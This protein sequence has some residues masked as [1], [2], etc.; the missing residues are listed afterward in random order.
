[1]NSF[2]KKILSIGLSFFVL[3]STSSFSVE[4]HYCC[5][6]LIDVGVFVHAETCNSKS[7]N[8]GLI[9]CEDSDESCCHNNHFNKIGQEDLK[10]SLDNNFNLIPNVFIG[11]NNSYYDLFLELR[12]NSTT[13]NDYRPPLLLRNF[14]I[15]YGTFLI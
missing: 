8:C 13:N 12:E 9:S 3:F 10:K 6:K 2:Y 15:L 5:D 7:Q 4:L 1:V 11:T 14:T